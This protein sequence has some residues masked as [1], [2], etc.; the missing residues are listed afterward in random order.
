MAQ[1]AAPVTTRRALG[2][3]Q[4]R[5]KSFDHHTAKRGSILRSALAGSTASGDALGESEAKKKWRVAIKTVVASVR[6]GNNSDGKHC[7][8]RAPSASGYGPIIPA[9]DAHAA[10]H[11]HEACP[12]RKWRVVIT[13]VIAS[14]R[15]S[16][17]DKYEEE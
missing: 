8:L 10:G 16:K 1:D 15:L 13:S 6:F 2:A 9:R 11:E 12:K 4:K 3:N 14:L 5:S 17:A 7:D